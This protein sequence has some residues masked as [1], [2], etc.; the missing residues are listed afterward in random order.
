MLGELKNFLNTEE[1]QDLRRYGLIL[2][3]LLSGTIATQY[4]AEHWL[5]ERSTSAFKKNV[6]TEAE[7][8]R[9]RRLKADSAPGGSAPE[10]PMPAES[11][12]APSPATY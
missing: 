9:L 1:F 12:A 11:Q 2:L 5:P 6:A 3:L 8:L 7:E 4:L 10:L